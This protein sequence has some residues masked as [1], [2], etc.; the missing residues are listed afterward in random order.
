[1]PDQLKYAQFCPISQLEAPSDWDIREF[2]WIFNSDIPEGT[3]KS[4]L[5][6][7]KKVFCKLLIIKDL[8]NCSSGG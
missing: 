6:L 3:T 1:V 2:D 7:P 8:L 4:L 5:L